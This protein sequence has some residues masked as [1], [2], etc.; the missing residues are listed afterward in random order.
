MDRHKRDVIIAGNWKMNKTID[1]T[2]S[3]IKKISPLVEDANCTVLFCVPY[4]DI[5]CAL[6]ESEGSSIYIAAQNCHFEKFG[7]YTGEVSAFMLKELGVK[8]V[9]IGHSERR[10]YFAETDATVNLRLKAALKEGLK[11]IVCVGESLQQR[12]DG[13]TFEIISMQLKLGLKNLSEQDIKRVVLAYEPIWAIGTGETA[14]A[15]Q[16]EQV[17]KYIRA[18]LETM[19]SKNVAQAVSILYGGSMNAKNCNDLLLKENIDGGLIGG[20]SLEVESF[21][22]IVK[23]AKSIK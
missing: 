11:A 22:D 3:F 20:A 1:E 6:K 8:Y 14:S 13:I 12:Q 10:Q 23:I 17:C 9:L 5:S 21:Y 2:E 19:F 15:D 18:V 7:A 4:T 16:A